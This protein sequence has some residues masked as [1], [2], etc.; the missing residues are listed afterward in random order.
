MLGESGGKPKSKLFHYN[1]INGKNNFY[2][3]FAG[4]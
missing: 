2:S 4:L 1:C 3:N